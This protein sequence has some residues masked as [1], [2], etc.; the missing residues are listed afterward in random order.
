MSGSVH[1][2]PCLHFSVSGSSALRGFS[3]S[4]N[5]A[6]HSISL[7]TQQVCCQQGQHCLLCID[8]L[9]KLQFPAVTVFGSESM[10]EQNKYKQFFF[11]ARLFFKS[12]PAFLK[13]LLF[14]VQLYRHLEKNPKLLLNSQHSGQSQ[15]RH[16]MQNY[17]IIHFR[18]T[19]STN[20]F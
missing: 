9:T 3:L 6:E 16:S 15:Q 12:S 20:I 8:L 5:A 18:T 13:L 7:S 11:K 14:Y 4:C 2:L 1:S 10:V 17:G 19:R